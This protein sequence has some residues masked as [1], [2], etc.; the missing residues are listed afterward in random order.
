MWGRRR[1]QLFS[2]TLCVMVIVGVLTSSSAVRAADDPQT[3][4][5]CEANQ[6]TDWLPA[7]VPLKEQLGDTSGDAVECAH[8]AG[9]SDDTVQQTNLGLAILRATT[10]APTFT[11]GVTRWALIT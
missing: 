6:T 4:P 8:P 5:Y 3:A 11:D 1:V 9:N 2:R 10:A 7:L